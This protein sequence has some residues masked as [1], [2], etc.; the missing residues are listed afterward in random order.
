MLPNLLGVVRHA[1]PELTVEVP[2][3]WIE[4]PPIAAVA[5]PEEDELLVGTEPPRAVAPP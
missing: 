3:L 1:H 4:E 5:P 2:L